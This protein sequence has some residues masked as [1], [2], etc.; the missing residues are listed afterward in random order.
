MRAS[1]AFPTTPGPPLVSILAFL[2]YVDASA[3]EALVITILEL[4][5]Y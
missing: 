4:L 2:I 1:L 3:I 5:E